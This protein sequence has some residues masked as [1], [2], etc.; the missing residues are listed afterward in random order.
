[1]SIMAS[2]ITIIW[3]VYSAVCSGAHQR[4]HQ[5]SASLAF[6]R[7]IHRWLVGSRHKEPVTRKM[8]RF[9]DVIMWEQWLPFDPF[10][11]LS[12]KCYMGAWIKILLMSCS[13]MFSKIV[14]HSFHLGCLSF[15]RFFKVKA[16]SHI[17]WDINNHTW[18]YF[19]LNYRISWSKYG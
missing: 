7:G 11:P 2:Q 5:S 18:P 1:M 8:Y 10:R 13:E 3:T 12:N 16:W 15:T 14:V 19:S 17:L 4:K 9:D 6:V